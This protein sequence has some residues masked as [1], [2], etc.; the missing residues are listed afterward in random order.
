MALG[1]DTLFALACL[2]LEIPLLA[3]IPFCDQ[4]K[5]WPKAS[6]ELYYEILNNKLVTSHIVTQG[7][8]NLTAFQIRNEYMVDLCDKLLAIHDGTRGGTYNTVRYA[9][10][11]DKDIILINPQDYDNTSDVQGKL[12]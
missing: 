4:E 6:K 7:A 11:I 9:Q 2:E 3:A 8:Y 5:R 12:F 1:G 10:S